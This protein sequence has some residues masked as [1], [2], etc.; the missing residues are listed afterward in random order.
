MWGK[1]INGYKI[2]FN[3]VKKFVKYNFANITWDKIKDIKVDKIP[4]EI[5]KKIDFSI[6]GSCIANAKYLKVK[7]SDTSKKY[8]IDGSKV[9][10]IPKITGKEIIPKINMKIKKNNILIFFSIN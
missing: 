3:L 2:L 8:P 1:A 9:P 10:I 7:S 4:T 5:D 6:P